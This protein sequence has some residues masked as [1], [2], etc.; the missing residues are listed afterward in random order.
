MPSAI[1][2][3]IVAVADPDAAAAELQST[4]GLR[5]SGGGRHDAHG[6]YN[7]LIWLG[8]SYLELMGVFDD[9]LADASW[10]GRHVRSILARA[11]AGFA[12][13]P[14]AAHELTSEIARLRERGSTLLDPV[15]GERVRPDGQVV[16]WSIGRLPSPDP[17]LGLVFLIE[18]DTS[19][20]EW[21]PADREARASETHPLGGPARL[22]R[23]AVPVQDPARTSLRLLREFGLQ[24]R[25]S[26]AGAGARDTTIGEPDAA[27]GAGSRGRR[28]APHDRDPGR[29]Q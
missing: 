7:R 28:S 5:A 10:W 14:L 11:P 9:G 25:P 19:G 3:V 4:L 17:D 18:H 24:F 22:V 27:A 1:D 2:H 20:A 13:V 15:A 6:T 21:Q 26:L 8:D 12:G 29:R 23:L 16:R